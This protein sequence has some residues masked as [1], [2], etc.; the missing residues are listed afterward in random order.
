MLGELIDQPE[1]AVLVL[2]DLVSQLEDNELRAGALSLYVCVLLALDRR[3]RACLAIQAA[4]QACPEHSLA[5]L[6]MRS[7]LAGLLDRAVVSLRKGVAI[8]RDRAG[9]EAA[10]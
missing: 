5:Q 2:E 1:Q 9:L 10:V 7:S 6:L 8:A 3:A 4:E